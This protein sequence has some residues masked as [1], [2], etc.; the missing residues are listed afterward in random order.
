MSSMWASVL[1][2]VPQGSVFLLY[3]DD[4]S[5]WVVNSMRLFADDANIWTKLDR[6]DSS[7]SF[8]RDLFSLCNWSDK[9]LLK[10][11]L[12]E[13]KLMHNGHSMPTRYYVRDVQKDKEL[14]VTE[15]KRDLGEYASTNLKSGLQY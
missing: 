13:C 4:L 15:E 6:D 14:Q 12:Q 9:W 10:F 3:V 7:W 2:R 8:Q 1:S 11:N 5:D